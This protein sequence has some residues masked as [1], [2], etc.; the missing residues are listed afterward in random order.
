MFENNLRKQSFQ[1]IE[2]TA[3]KSRQEKEYFKIVK[4]IVKTYQKYDEVKNI[5]VCLVNS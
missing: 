5:D 3:Q 4:N 1:G 2:Q